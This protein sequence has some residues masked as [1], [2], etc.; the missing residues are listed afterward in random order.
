MK[1][2]NLVTVLRLHSWRYS[3]GSGQIPERVDG[4]VKHA[5]SEPCGVRVLTTDVVTPQYDDDGPVGP[6]ELSACAVT[7]AGC[8]ARDLP[9]KTTGGCQ[10]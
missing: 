8:R 6:D 10:G 9:S 4:V 1:L 3:S 7:K 5:A 2:P